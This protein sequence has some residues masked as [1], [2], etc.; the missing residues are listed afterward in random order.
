[1]L[2]SEAVSNAAA[3]TGQVVDTAVLVRWLSELDGR[4]AF[5][6]YRAEAWTPYDPVADLGAE[7]LVPFPWDGLYVHHLEAMTYFTDGEY[8]RYENARAMSEKTLGDFRRFMQRT[9]AVPCRPGFPTDRRGGIGVTVIPPTPDSPF[10]WLSAYALAV[11]HGFVGT[12]EDWLSSIVR[13]PRGPGGRPN[14]LDNWCFVGGAAVNQRG[15]T[16]YED[17]GYTV[18]RWIADITGGDAGGAGSVEVDGDGLIISQGAGDYSAT[19]ICQILENPGA[20]AGRTVTVSVLCQTNVGESGFVLLANTQPYAMAFAD[21]Q[22]RDA[23]ITL[24][25][26]LPDELWD[27]AVYFYGAVT[28]GQWNHGILRAVKLEVGEGQTLAEFSD[29]EWVLSDAPPNYG[30]EKLKCQL[31]QADGDDD[32]ANK[33]ITFEGG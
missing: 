19:S 27:L 15:E 8:D 18:D 20:L 11:K 21:V 22:G 31:S 24:T 4:L 7:M 12:E 28:S 5:E 25:V 23:L 6:F 32:Y 10:F 1:M 3:L 26:P 9:Q 13:G 16:F 33:T 30:M 14:L 17:D 29:G 2:I